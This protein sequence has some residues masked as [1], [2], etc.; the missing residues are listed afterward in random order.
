MEGTKKWTLPSNNGIGRLDEVGENMCMAEK[1]INE[2]KI[3]YL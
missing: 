3:I 2:N 1:C